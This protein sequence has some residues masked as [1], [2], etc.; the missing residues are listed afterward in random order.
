VADVAHLQ[1]HE[2]ACSKLAV[3]CQ[4]EQSKFPAPPRHLQAHANRPD[5]FELQWGFL[6]YELPLFQGSRVVVVNATVSMIGS[7]CW[8]ASILQFFEKTLDDPKL[9]DATGRFRALKLRTLQ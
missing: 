4:I 2:I 6:A 5:L 9:S 1:L 3:D 7:F 8:G